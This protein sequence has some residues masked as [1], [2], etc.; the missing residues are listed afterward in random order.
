MF[1]GVKT[2]LGKRKEK[3]IVQ[4]ENKKNVARKKKTKDKN[5][6]V[7]EP[8]DGID[9]SCIAILKQEPLE[10]KLLLEPV[11]ELSR[12]H[13]KDWDY[14]D[15]MPIIKLLAGR[16]FIDGKGDNREGAF[17]FDT[18]K[19]DFDS[20]LEKHDDIRGL[21]DPTYVIAD[22]GAIVNP[23]FLLNNYPQTVPLPVNFGGTNYIWTFAGR[24]RL[25]DA[26]HL[27]GWIQCADPG[28]NVFRFDT[29]SPAMQ[30]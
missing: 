1:S 8:D 22:I 19:L 14:N 26:T 16:P 24:N 18:I 30:Y 20:Y 17:A 4:K 7:E 11:R 2:I 6:E 5:L 10:G 27:I 29:T 13:P 12:K 9:I 21:I 23:N 3:N 28:I 15:L 25:V